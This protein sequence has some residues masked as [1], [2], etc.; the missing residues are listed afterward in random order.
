[1]RVSPCRL[2]DRRFHSRSTALR[3]RARPQGF[4]ELKNDIGQR[5]GQRD[6]GPNDDLT[7]CITVV[8]PEESGNQA[9]LEKHQRHSVAASYPLAVLLDF[10][11][12]DEVER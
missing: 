11:V 1:M 7:S 8:Q 12:P 2:P 3:L 9:D 6:A 5:H 4:L 10:P